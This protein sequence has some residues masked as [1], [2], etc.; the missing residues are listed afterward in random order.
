[1]TPI[2]ARSTITVDVRFFAVLRERAGTERRSVELPG[3]S[4][5]A[6]LRAHLREWLPELPDGYA[7]AVGLSYATPD[8]VLEDGD[9]VALIP[10]VSGG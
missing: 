2:A 8:R 1:V 9:E 7:V 3:R 5:V 6:D 4:T 10:P